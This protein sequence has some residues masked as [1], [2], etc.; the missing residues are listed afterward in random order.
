MASG[1]I[2]S[3]I[4]D[5]FQSR[6]DWI[7]TPNTA[8]NQS[9]VTAKLYCW[10]TDTETTNGTISSTITIDGNTKSFSNGTGDI[11]GSWVYLASYK[12]TVTHDSD[13]T[14]SI[15]I[16]A[17]VSIKKPLTNIILASTSCSGTVT[18]NTIQRESEITSASSVTLGD[19]CSI[20]WAPKSASFRYKIKFSLGGWSYTTDAIHP[21]K[22]SSYTYT[23]YEIPLDVARQITSAKTGTMTATLYTYSDSGAT[24]QVGSTSSETFT[25]TVPSSDATLPTVKMALSPVTSLESP[26][27]SLYI[28]GKSKVKASFTGS[29]VKYGASISS[30]SLTVNGTKYESPYTSNWLSMSGSIE[31]VGTITDSRGYSA[32]TTQA[33][34]VIAYSYPSVIPYTGDNAITCARC[35]EN[36]TLDPSG[37]YLKIRAGRKY[38]KVVSDGTQNNYCILRYRYKTASASS[39]SSWATIIAKT[40][41]S[42]VVNLTI[43]NV[44][45][46]KTTS[47]V[48]QIGVIDDLG[49]AATQSFVVP[50][51][52]VD[53][54][55]RKGGNGA[56]FGK[57]SEVEKC[58]E[59]AEEWNLKF[60]GDRWK[61]LGASDDVLDSESELG[62]KRTT[63]NCYYRVEGENHVYVAFNCAFEYLGDPITVSENQIPSQYRPTNSVYALCTTND[64]G[65]A[66][67]CVNDS[68]EV[69]IDHV[70]NM[71]SAETASSFNVEWIDGYIDYWVLIQ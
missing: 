24:T 26:F 55:L 10:R 45:S 38:S 31:V 19:A 50:T 37:T 64:H 20:T 69:I 9:T 13:G 63:K 51:D 28:Q 62:R 66:R 71:A 15:T 44:V 16:S 11:T 59:I 30:Y 53:F 12:K 8:N 18:L 27:D 43:P 41:S 25:V 65:V 40:A 6:I 33:I 42:D 52:S 54:N 4:N 56:G 17:T 22:T 57:Y 46:S 35:T 70:Q 5:S 49:N 32:S 61:E 48:V 14:K 1:I 7:S 21:N 2:P 3:E 23:E 34:D 36:G 29:G 60:C 68:G 47:Y 67:V 39:Y 58:V